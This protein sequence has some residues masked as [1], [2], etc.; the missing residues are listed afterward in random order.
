MKLLKVDLSPWVPSQP[1]RGGVSKGVIRKSVCAHR[2]C[3]PSMQPGRL[4]QPRLSQD[5]SAWHWHYILNEML[6]HPEFFLLLKARRKSIEG[7]LTRC[8]FLK[9]VY[10]SRLC[11]RA[12]WYN[13]GW[14]KITQHDT[15]ILFQT[16]C[17]VTPSF[18]F[19]WKA[20]KASIQ[21]FDPFQR[22]FYLLPLNFS[23]WFKNYSS[24]FSGLHS[25]SAC[26]PMIPSTL[27]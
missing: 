9:T 7:W 1:S 5:Y 4:I 14:A 2:L 10:A 17:T 22:M 21:L 25:P 20:S 18:F 23:T 24:L 15:A 8:K 13:L 12:D 26:W 16:K 6:C 11:S 19:C 27:V 3:F